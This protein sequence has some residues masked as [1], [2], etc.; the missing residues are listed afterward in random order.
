MTQKAIIFQPTKTAMQSGKAKTK[1][2]HF[3]FISDDKKFV[4]PMMGWIGSN[5]TTR[6]L[7]LTFDTAE[8][9]IAYAESK[10]I[11]YTVRQPHKRTLKKKSYADN[12]A[13][14]QRKYSD[15][16]SR[17]QRDSYPAVSKDENNA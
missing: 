2:W 6:Q 12:F 1:S 14:S 4:E 10:K 9:A 8:E 15:I 5:D 3:K 7:S 13:F 16:A 11:E 17:A